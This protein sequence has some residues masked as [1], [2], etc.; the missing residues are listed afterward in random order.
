LA[1]KAG[2]PLTITFA[3]PFAESCTSVVANHLGSAEA[4]N[5]VVASADVNGF[6]CENS[7][8]GDV[9]VSYIAMGN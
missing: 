2:T 5:I 3:K 9:D 8:A 6:V 4:V 7:S 1:G